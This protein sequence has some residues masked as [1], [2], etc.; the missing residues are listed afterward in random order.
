[1]ANM[2]YCRFEN[3]ASDLYDCIGAMEEVVEGDRPTLSLN[4]YEVP[5]F[6]NLAQLCRNYLDLYEEIY[7][8]D[9]KILPQP[10]NYEDDADDTVEDEL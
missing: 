7:R 9:E 4:Q 2:S 6:H 8:H 5:A 3:T 10:Y 1:M